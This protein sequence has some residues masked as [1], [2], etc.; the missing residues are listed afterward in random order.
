MRK[1]RFTESH[2]VSILKDR[3]A[4]VPLADLVLRAPAFSER[5]EGESA[6]IRC[7]TVILRST[8]L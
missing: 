3:D 4:G 7:E 6:V 5:D 8:R 1:S 2:I